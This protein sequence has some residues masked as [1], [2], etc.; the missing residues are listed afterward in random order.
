MLPQLKHMHFSAMPS[1]EIA[2][3]TN[4]VCLAESFTY[5]A[6]HT[7]ECHEGPRGC[8]NC[9]YCQCPHKENFTL[10]QCLL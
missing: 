5:L 2:I 3:L 9:E 10:S 7:A 1:N 6:L 4:E 8:F